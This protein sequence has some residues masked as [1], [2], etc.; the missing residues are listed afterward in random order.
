MGSKHHWGH[1]RELGR[2]RQRSGDRRCRVSTSAVSRSVRTTGVST[3]VSV[4]I[5]GILILGLGAAHAVGP[6][7]LFGKFGSTGTTGGLFKVPIGVGIDQSNSDVYVANGG[8]N[9]VEKFDALG[10][11]VLTFGGRVDEATAGDVCMIASGD[12]CRVGSSGAAS[13]YF[14]TATGVGIDPT[15]GDVY[16]VDSGNHR[17]QKFG[18][19]GEFILMFGGGVDA[20][21]GGNVCTAASGD[22]CQAGSTGTGNGQFSTWSL[23]NFIAI[24][25]AGIVY[26]GDENRIQEF[27]SE[28]VYQSKIALPGA[29]RTV[30]L[31]LASSGDVY[32]NSASLKGVREYDSSG[33]LLETLDESGSPQAVATD[34]AGHVF[35]ADSSGGTHVLEYDSAGSLVT[36][37]G[38]G[39]GIG[40]SLG[41]A[42]ANASEDVYVTDRTNNEVVIFGTAPSIPP[43]IDSES[44]AELGVR[45]AIV[46][47]RIDPDMLGTTYYVQFGTD[48][49][50]SGGES[51][52]AP[53][54]ELGGGSTNV[55]RAAAV[56]LEGLQPD[57]VYH[58]RFVAVNAAGTV[59][60][61]DR[62]LKTYPVVT[63][64]LPDGR[65]YEQVSPVL[66]NGNEAGASDRGGSNKV[67]YAVARGDGDGLLFGGTGPFGTTFSGANENFVARRSEAGWT[68]TAA[69]PPGYGADAANFFAQRPGFLYP[70]IDL[71]HVMFTAGGS[72]VNALPP[73]GG[74]STS[75]APEAAYLAGE[76]V[77]VEP[78]WLSAPFK[79]AFAAAL[80]EPGHIGI[81]DAIGAVGGSPDLSTAYFTYY[82]TLLP[83]DE[84]RAANFNIEGGG[85]WGFYEWKDGTLKLVGELPNKTYDPFGAVPAVTLAHGSMTLFVPDDFNNEI[86]ADGSRAFFVSPDPESAHPSEDPPELYVREDGQDT[87]LVS[88]NALAPSVEGLPAAAP[89]PEAIVPWSNPDSCGGSCAMYMYASPDGSHA[90]FRSMDKLA[91]SMDGEEPTGSGPWT[92]DFNVDTKSLTYLPNIDGPILA[93]SE[94]GSEI[95]F[96][97]VGASSALELYAGGKIT[98]IAE[99]SQ[100]EAPLIAPVRATLSGQMFVFETNAVVAP[101]RFHNYPSHSQVY[102]YDV[103]TKELTCVS[104]PPSGTQPS[105]D[106]HLS[107]DD[108]QPETDIG[109]EGKKRIVGSR[110]I[111]ADGDR[112]F[113]DTTDALVSQDINGKRDV[114][115]WENG[116]VYLI[117][118]GVGANPSMFLDNSES[119]NDVFFTTTDSLLEGDTDG[120]YDVYDARVG[121][122]FPRGVSAAECVGVC[123]PLTSPPAPPSFVSQLTGTSGNLTAPP[124]KRTTVQQP[125]V[126][127][128]RDSVKGAKATIVASVPSA[129][130]LVASGKGLS[131]VTRR[132]GKAG[133]TTVTLTLS[134]QDQLVLAQH[135]GRRLKVSVKLLFTPTHGSR[136]SASVTLL[137]G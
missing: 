34:A 43:S 70:S 21:T 137:M 97:K 8:N 1:I 48:T 20:T 40:A 91:K 116:H 24:G 106:A 47:A 66:K 108:L 28:G 42:E 55:D 132:L 15:S 82:G 120:S 45:T 6:L 123:Q 83:E 32:V 11:F 39:S 14:K 33:T 130:R 31:A 49:S 115:E 58:Y 104:C 122:G 87:V 121:G 113:F 118:S 89:G 51:P 101:G 7:P 67:F 53:G 12:P 44:V 99:W 110:G 22:T 96:E 71:N 29:G 74:T 5:A 56:P 35:V 41:V 72:F 79:T 60:G 85:P 17:V 133:T 136:L 18:P 4:V 84:S 111:S 73:V 90:F 62:V 135:P 30:A 102:R 37:F 134:K 65:V 57:T 38:S 112:V 10:K 131:R 119:G 125:T 50:Y 98:K 75:N 78:A 64:G 114:Y 105:G 81:P 95:V 93:S 77:S 23:G 61:A 124:A 129:G 16:V 88:R 127:V 36:E 19:S 13:G 94:D 117:S 52:V 80:P 63:R 100:P 2:A 128:L 46:Q 68:T 54:T 126:T 9:R 76:D 107:N 27:N 103:A 109:G 92:Y 59:R 3:F 25:A 69:L 86:S 26:A